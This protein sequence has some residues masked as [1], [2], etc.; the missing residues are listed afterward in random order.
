MILMRSEGGA[1]DCIH[2]ELWF[3]TV[4]LPSFRVITHSEPLVGVLETVQTETL[5]L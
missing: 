1:W 5:G 4:Q 3:S 2:F